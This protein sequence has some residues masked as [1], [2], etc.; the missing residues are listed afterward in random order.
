MEVAAAQAALEQKMQAQLLPKLKQVS[1]HE[2][3]HNKRIACQKY[4]QQRVHF[5]SDAC[6]LCCLSPVPLPSWKP[7]SIT[8]PKPVAGMV[9]D[10]MHMPE[11]A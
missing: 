10:T 1:L 5:L 11:L 8:Y 2:L 4:V 3:K 9:Q 6:S 7:V